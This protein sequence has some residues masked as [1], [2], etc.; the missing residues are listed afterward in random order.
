MTDTERRLAADRAV[1]R[2]A[3]RNAKQGL[4]QI[5]KDLKARSV[6]A[7]IVDKAKD[8]ATEAMASGLEIASESKGLV[9]AVAAGIGLWWFRAKLLGNKRK[10]AVHADRGTVDHPRTADEE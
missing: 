6:P 1:R 7:R 3:K 9:A 4:R 2:D 5:R 10:D 8:E